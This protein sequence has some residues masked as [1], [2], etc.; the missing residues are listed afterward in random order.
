M[1]AV[2]SITF[3]SMI[4]YKAAILISVLG[5]FADGQFAKVLLANSV[6]LFVIGLFAS[7]QFANG[8]FARGQLANGHFA[9][10]LSAN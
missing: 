10:G 3:Y 5:F 8:H 9:I 7:G 6:G 1:L 4:K 2:V